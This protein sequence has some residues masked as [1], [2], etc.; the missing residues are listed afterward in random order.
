MISLFFVSNLFLD[1]CHK[2]AARQGLEPQYPGPKP[3]VLP[4]DD[5][6]KEKPY[7]IRFSFSYYY[8]K[9]VL[10]QVIPINHSQTMTLITFDIIN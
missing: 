2:F 8:L 1:K 10:M 9:F 5:R 4:L 7:K 3:G 6:A